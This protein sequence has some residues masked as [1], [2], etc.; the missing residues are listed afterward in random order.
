M[1]SERSNAKNFRRVM[2]A[3]Q[4]IHADFFGGNCG[5]MRCFTSDEC[6]DFF[7]C[8]PVN[9]RTRSSGHNAYRARL[10]RT[11]TENFYRTI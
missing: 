4:K 8:D 1:C 10:F 3:E 2:S 9:F 7:I 11:E 6:V 5:P